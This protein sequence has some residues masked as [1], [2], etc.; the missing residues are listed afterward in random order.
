[1]NSKGRLAAHLEGRSPKVLAECTID[2]WKVWL[3]YN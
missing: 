1:M 3:K 2:K